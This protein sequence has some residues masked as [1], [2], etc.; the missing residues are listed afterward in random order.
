MPPEPRPLKHGGG[1]PPL[2]GIPPLER[3]MIKNVLHAR[4]DPVWFA[5]NILRLRQ[6]PGEKSLDEDPGNSWSLDE[7][8][9]EMLMAVGDCS[10]R[11]L[12][13][14]PKL[15]A[16]SNMISVAA[17]QGPGKTF[18]A[19]MIVHWFG[20]CY[21][22]L[23]VCTAP[24]LQ[25]VTTRLFRE[26]EKIRQRATP[27]YAELM[28]VQATTIRWL[29]QPTWYAIAETGATPESLQGFHD[30]YLLVIVDEASGVPEP[31]FAVMHGTMSAGALVIGLLIGNPTRAQGTFADSHRRADLAKDFYRMHVSYQN[32]KRVKAS[33]VDYMRRQYGE[34]SPVFKVRCLGEF[35]TSSVGQLISLEWIAAARNREI[36]LRVGDGSLPRLRVS[37]DCAAGGADETICCGVLRFDTLRVGLRMTRHSFPLVSAS[38]D[39]ADAAEKLFY[40]LN[41]RKGI[42]DFVVDSLGVGVG[43]V[44]ELVSRGH[45]VVAYQGGGASDDTVRWRNRRVQSYIGLRNDLRDNA[46]T[47]NDGFLEPLDWNDCE[48]QLCSIQ[49]TTNERAEDLVSKEEL[50]KQGLPS[51]DMA[52]ALAMQYATTAPATVTHAMH[53]ADVFL[54]SQVAVV[55]SKINSGLEDW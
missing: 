41:G 7:W 27:G 13:L 9:K 51:P 31:M 53:K 29:N 39:T 33:W 16:I 28:H 50:Q 42:D 22:G 14:K 24:K 5:E 17:C 25:Q 6:L 26:F 52:D 43:A 46:L 2:H 15:N 10:R 19:A 45:A 35:S 37:V 40:A 20:F 55:H 18:G 38:K 36:D 44:G 11:Y 32:S 30:K 23:Q 48:G 47:F 54:P 21:Q 8:Q 12:G 3:T 49:S 34:K 1:R 4:R